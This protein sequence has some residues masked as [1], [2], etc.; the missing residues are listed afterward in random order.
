[1]AIHAEVLQRR[2]PGIIS[3]LNTKWHRVGLYAFLGVTLAHWAEHVVQ[4]LQIWLLDMPRPEARGVL[5]YLFPT[6]VS[7]EWLH[8]FYALAMLVGLFVLLPGFAGRSRFWWKVAIGIQLWHHVEHLLLLYQAQTDSILFGKDV[9]TSVLQLVFQRAELHLWY[10]ALVFIPM[11]LAMY[12]HAYPPPGERERGI[13]AACSCDRIEARRS[14][15][16]E[17]QAIASV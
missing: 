11:V 16:S 12:W 4:A 10:N 7:E 9:P 13:T 8:Y 3:D 17:R 6:L 14:E 1:M 5:G 15:R 2:G